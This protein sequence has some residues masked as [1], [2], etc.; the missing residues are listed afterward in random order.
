MQKNRISTKT[1]EN[2]AGYLSDQHLR[3][4]FEKFV[5]N[6]RSCYYVGADVT[7]DETLEA[8]RGRCPF[9]L[10]IPSKPSK[11]GIKIFAVVD[12]KMFYTSNLEIY[13]GKQP[14][15][16]FQFSN[17]SSDV[18]ERLITPITKT[19]RNVTADNWLSDVTLLQ[20]LSDKH[21]LSYV[22]ILRKNKWQIPKVMK[23]LKLR[24]NFSSFFCIS[25]RRNACCIIRPAK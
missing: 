1:V 16:P 25:K 5:N 12:S 13:P 24:E 19:G 20:T 3:D 14:E 10:Y 7:I 18:L 17:K 15:G 22:R 8:F 11:Y 21:H 23:D 9:T 6:C 4:F 2:K